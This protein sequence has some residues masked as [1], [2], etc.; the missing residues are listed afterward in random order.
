MTHGMVPVTPYTAP[1]CHTIRNTPTSIVK[2]FIYESLILSTFGGG[3]G[4]G[5]SFMLA[6]PNIHHLICLIMII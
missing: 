6:N 5:W 2:E 3:G 1:I 4:G